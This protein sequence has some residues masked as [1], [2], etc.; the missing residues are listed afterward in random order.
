MQIEQRLIENSRD[1]AWKSADLSHVLPYLANP[2]LLSYSG[3]KRGFHGK[4]DGRTLLEALEEKKGES[5]RRRR[6][7]LIP[8]L[9]LPPI[10]R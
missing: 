5:R 9:S 7:L 10:D 2:Y 3:D 1:Y 4:M 8:P 6:R